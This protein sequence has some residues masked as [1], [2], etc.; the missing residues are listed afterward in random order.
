[1]SRQDVSIATPDGEARAFVF[2]PGHGQGPWPTVLF[3]MDGIA[4]REALFEMAERL[5]A[6]GYYVLLPDMFWRLGPYPPLDPKKVFA[7]CA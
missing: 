7:D 4:I 5:A 1:M 6:H 3:Y 2:T